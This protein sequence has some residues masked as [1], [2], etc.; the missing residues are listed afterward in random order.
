MR[1]L[2]A[3]LITLLLIAASDRAAAQGALLTLDQAEI[4]LSDAS[5]PPPDAAAWQ[6]QALPDLRPPTRLHA[7]GTAWYRLRFEVPQPTQDAQIVYFSRL[8]DVGVVYVNGTL[9]GRSE[10]FEQP[11][12]AWAPQRLTL[13]PELLRG[14]INTLHVR[15]QVADGGTGVMPRVRIGDKAAVQRAVERER[16]L[17]IT[18]AQM[19]GMF[20]LTI[21]I[22]TLLI[23]AGRRREQMFGYF[24]VAALAKAL[25]IGNSL[26]YFRDAPQPLTLLFLDFALLVGS[27]CL[28]LYCLRF[29]GWRW[30]RV[31]KA[32][33][34]LAIA[35]FVFDILPIALPEYSLPNANAQLVQLLY[36]LPVLLVSYIV[37]RQPSLEAVLLALAH[38]YAFGAGVWALQVPRIEGLDHSST[39]M[40]PLFLVMGWIITRR[41]ARS[42]TDAELLKARLEQ[43]VEDK[44]SE[45]ASKSAQVLTLTRQQALADERQRLMADIHDGIGGQLISTLSL[46]E[47]G[48]ASPHD[49][50]AA[51]RECIDDLRL[52]ID[53][54]EPSDHDLLPALG[55]LRYRF[56]G[57]LK[58]IGVK[59]DWQVR[60]VPKLACLTPLNLLHVL[61]ILQEAFTNI[62]KHAQADTIRV[63]TGVEPAAGR[64][65]IR[66]SDNGRG[67]AAVRSEG[68]GLAN[69][70]RRAKAIGGDLTV[71]PSAPG[72]TLELLLP[73]G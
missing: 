65:Y 43:R 26:G 11:P 64:V 52:T 23:W 6:T 50:A 56:D 20:S 45:L 34:S 51:L 15:L 9:V 4:V 46:V 69:M 24:G 41:F 49:L 44:R 16:F 53:S 5:E 17:G 27:V 32:L 35:I 61:R 42:L 71:G 70:L 37:V 29:A 60:E 8:R 1:R 55:N 62:L 39:H 28:L 3:L 72:T 68:H 67:F 18:S 30:P 36:L 73:V 10:E 47:Q 58:Q 40:V 7:S 31:E 2:V 48:S 22:G 66:I 54:L 63:E 25:W 38:G 19:A 33:W 12:P 21:G 13:A 14:G 59:L 57:R